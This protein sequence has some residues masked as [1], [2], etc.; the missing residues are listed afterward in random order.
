METVLLMKILADHNIEGQLRVLASVWTST[1]WLELWQSLDGKVETLAGI[2]VSSDLPDAQ[3]WELCQER[4]ML[5]VTSNR[6]ADGENSLE[7]TMRRLC[8]QDSLP[9]VTIADADRVMW[10]R[11]YAEQVAVKVLEVIL[12]IDRLKGTRRIFVP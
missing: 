1:D 5:L 8:R 11:L 12:D 2:G 4:G 3:L 6:N 10:D 9:V 7:A